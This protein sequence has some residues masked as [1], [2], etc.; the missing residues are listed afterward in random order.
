MRT[1][2]T[3]L[4]VTVLAACRAT[5]TV[6][7]GPAAPATGTSTTGSPTSRAAVDAFFAAMKSG[8][9]QAASAVW[10]SKQGASR[11]YMQRTELELRLLTMQC[12]LAHE[13]LKVTGPTRT[14]P[15]SAFFRVE[16][17]KSGRAQT[18]DVITVTG[19][20]SRWYVA[21]PKI[22]GIIAQGCGG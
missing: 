3:V 5:T 13:S 2:L 22:S 17:T 12:Y 20:R 4:V 14:K 18:T 7:E 15:D 21:D 8:D 1:I 19:P 10:G 9:L 16:L 6:V 11:D